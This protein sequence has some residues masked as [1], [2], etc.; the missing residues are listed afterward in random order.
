MTEA[1]TW[2]ATRV[3]PAGDH[4]G[5]NQAGDALVVTYT[6]PS[7]PNARVSAYFGVVKKNNRYCPTSE[8]DFE[9]N[10]GEPGEQVADQANDEIF[11]FD[12]PTEDE[13]TAAAGR[14]AH[15]WSTRTFTVN[16]FFDG[17][18]LPDTRP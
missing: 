17:H 2:T 10:P 16:D 6:L 5:D 13:A 11:P 15:H 3:A 4:F 1:N 12:Y 8:I 7:A 18:T 14:T 9:I